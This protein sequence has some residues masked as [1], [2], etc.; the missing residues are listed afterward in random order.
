MMTS[1][2][3]LLILEGH[4]DGIDERGCPAHST[5]KGRSSLLRF[6]LKLDALATGG[7][8]CLH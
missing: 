3:S 5:I 7:S 8:P 6:A 2:A 1:S 4:R